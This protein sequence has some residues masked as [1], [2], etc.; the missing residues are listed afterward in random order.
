M[1]IDSHEREDAVAYQCVFTE[2]FKAYAM[3]FHQWDNDGRELPH[4]NRFPLP[5]GGPF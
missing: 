1:Y 3:C 5:N 4:L 2:R